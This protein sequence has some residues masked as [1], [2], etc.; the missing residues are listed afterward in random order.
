MAT[1]ILPRN[2][3]AIIFDLFGTLTNGQAD[4]DQRII[5]E[6]NLQVDYDTSAKYVCTT[7]WKSEEQ[8]H[9]EIIS[10]LNLPNTEDTREKLKEIFR[11]DLE[12]E[13]LE[14]EVPSLLEK[15]SY[16]YKLGVISDI[17]NPD[18]NLLGRHNLE[19]FFSA[20]VF[21]YEEGLLKPDKKIMDL[22]LDRLGLRGENVIMI[23]DSVHSD[24]G[25]AQNSGVDFIL[26]DKKGKNPNFS[27]ERVKTLEELEKYF[28]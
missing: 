22:M 21:S 10:G 24:Y 9:N 7:I 25:L 18:Y 11:R 12:G 6:W 14:K 28:F 17:P 16:R 20:R 8:Y 26:M 19:G 1:S 23:G 5:D 2:K 4:P 27:G 13:Y 15:L 3:R